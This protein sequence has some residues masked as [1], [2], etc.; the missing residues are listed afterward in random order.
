MINLTAP[1]HIIY[2]STGGNTEHVMEQ[3]AQYWREQGV[4]VVLHRS[5]QTS[6]SVITENKY[7]LFATSTWDHGM[8][9]PFFNVLLEQMQTADFTGKTASFIGLGD[10]RYEEHYFC[11]GMTVL[12][13]VWEKNHG[14]AV[15]VAL[16]IGR[17]PF[18]E[19]I[20]KAVKTWADTTLPL[21]Q[22]QGTQNEVSA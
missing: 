22:V 12:K 20:E 8:I 11:A 6:L 16:T 1:I 9:N 15:G 7:F 5:E 19:V 10:R 18:E 3:V 4:G 13:E 2:A 14:A 21:Y 17:E